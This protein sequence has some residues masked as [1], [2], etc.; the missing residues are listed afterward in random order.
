MSTVIRWVVAILGLLAAV[1]LFTAHPEL[2]DD[3]GVD[4]VAD[5]PPPSS[6]T[7]TATTPQPSSPGIREAIGH[8]HRR[9]V[10]RTRTMLPP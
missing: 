5:P 2:L 4:P 6:Q 3:D 10:R 8:L 9:R 7:P 1:A